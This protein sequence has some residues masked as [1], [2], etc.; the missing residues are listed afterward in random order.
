MAATSVLTIA[1]WNNLL[2]QIN[3]LAKSP[4]QG[5]KALDVLPLVT[6]PHKWS[7]ADISAV[8][9]KLS[10]ICSNNV[11][12]A[13]ATGKWLRSVIDE[14]NTAI[15]KGWCNCQQPCCVPQG[16]G[17]VRITPGGYSVT[18]PFSEIITQ[19]LYGYVSYSDMV[20]AMGSG[21]VANLAACIGGPTGQIIRYTQ[22]HLHWTNCIYQ[23]RW[24]DNG[25]I[26]QVGGQDEYWYTCGG[27]DSTVVSSGWVPTLSPS[28]QSSTSV[29]SPNYY[30]QPMPGGGYNY[31]YQAGCWY[32]TNWIGYFDVDGYVYDLSVTSIC[33]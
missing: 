24:V 29:G 10:A 1:A 26:R 16:S 27:S 13:P 11:F 22:R 5:C 33:P 12:N 4:P 3:N 2:T 15:R 32:E 23:D 8:R 9:S 17:T 7:G 25:S 21:V 20:A 19:Y 31:D 18:I 14:L 28:Y 30:D 6:A